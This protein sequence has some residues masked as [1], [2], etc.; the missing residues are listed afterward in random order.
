MT[1]PMTRTLYRYGRVLTPGRP[2]AT[3][4]VV[5][6][7]TIGWIG[8]ERA[9]DGHA[10]GVDRAVDLGGALVTPA[11][12][13]AH[14][15]ATQT[16]I[17]LRGLDLT[18]AASLADALD[19]VA[20]HARARR[21][22]VV[23]GHGWD[24]T[25]W[26]ERRPP[27]AA[28]LDRATYGGVA[29]LS[30]IDGHSA[31]VSS[32][33]VAAVP[34]I[35]AAVG[36]AGNGLISQEAH[37][38]A[39]RVGR[40]A[41]TPDDRRAAHRAT[42]AQAAQAG[43]GC[44]HELAGPDIAGADDLVALLALAREEPGPEVIGYWGELLAIDA[45]RRLGAA[46][47]AGDLFADGAIGSRTAAVSAPYTDAPTT[48]GAQYLRSDQVRD[49]V[50]A[51]TEAGLQAG[52]HVIGDAA[53]RAVVDGLT[54]AADQ[55]GAERV[56]AARHRLEHVEMI[57]AAQIAELA[58][59]GVVASVQPAFDALWGGDRGMYAKRLGPQRALAM[60]PFGSMAAAGV[61]L[62]FGSDTPV[63]PLAP[64]AA[65]RAA[66]FHHVPEQRLSPLAAFAAH[67]VG[68]WRAAR[69]DPAI[70]AGHAGHAGLLLPGSVATFAVWQAGPLGLDGLPD[71]RPDRPLPVCR[72]TVV[73]GR[74]IWGEEG[75]RR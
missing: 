27:T 25:R 67:T 71:L 28:E 56:V 4:F 74:Q 2:D 32:A 41:L 68:G 36:F 44:F 46:G 15:H 13:D 57:D 48:T 50:V 38:V 17:A 59:L 16:G 51:C 26:P 18:G 72:A 60:N 40:E 1:T 29:Y 75:D 34:E 35:R 52:F 6:G 33:L 61:S 9:A 31:V 55:L 42:R 65:V 43:I 49:H 8:D 24:E 37:H 3:A 54:A 73:G 30:R 70:H 53:A 39:R 22:G 14:V 69:R 58:R 11:F 63:T 10:D 5:D 62:A 12:V 66:A 20:R 64:W 45:T 7:A 19:R 23:L 47:A 21:G